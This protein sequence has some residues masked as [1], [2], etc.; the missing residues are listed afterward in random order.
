MSDLIYTSNN[1]KNLQLL[2]YWRFKFLQTNVVT[3][4]RRNK[5]GSDK[6]FICTTRLEK[7]VIAIPKLLLWIFSSTTIFRSCH[8]QMNSFLLFFQRLS[9]LS[10]ILYFDK[11]LPFFMNE[12][13]ISTSN[14]YAEESISKKLPKVQRVLL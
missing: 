14:I 11:F 8:L 1:R 5:M 13:K 6:I 9:I 7:P 12:T 2:K 10:P 3:K 4:S